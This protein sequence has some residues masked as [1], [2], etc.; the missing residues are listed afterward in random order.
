LWWIESAKK[1]ETRKN[2]IEKAVQLVSENKTMSDYYYLGNGGV[3]RSH[4][5][6]ELMRDM[7][8]KPY[9]QLLGAWRG[10]V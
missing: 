3:D 1:E 7:M 8:R 10:C 9:A 5:D 6:P 4:A 2:R